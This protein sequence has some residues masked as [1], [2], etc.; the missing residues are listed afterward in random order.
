MANKRQRKKNGKKLQRQFDELM[1][2]VENESFFFDAADEEADDDTPFTN[3]F[4]R[5]HE[6]PVSSDLKREEDEKKKSTT[7]SYE[8]SYDYK[9]PLLEMT[10]KEENIT[11]RIS[12]LSRAQKK[13]AAIEQTIGKE[14]P[15]PSNEN[16][17]NP[18]GFDLGDI[19]IRPD[20][21]TGPIPAINTQRPQSGVFKK[22][23]GRIA[24]VA[25]SAATGIGIRLAFG[26]AAASLTTPL[27][28]AI[29]LGAAAGAASRVIV[30]SFDKEKRQQ[31][32]WWATEIIKGITIGSLTGG[33]SFG[34]TDVVMSSGLGH[35]LV[36]NVKD[37]MQGDS[38]LP[39]AEKPTVATIVTEAQAADAPITE[40]PSAT[41]PQ[42][43]TAEP[44]PAAPQLAAF[45]AKNFM[46]EEQFKGLPKHVQK[47]ATS[48]NP[49]KFLSFC[50]QAAHHLYNNAPNSEAAQK[51]SAGLLDYAT[52]FAEAHHITGTPVLERINANLAFLEA[53]YLKDIKS[54]VKH[55][56]RSGDAVNNY[57]SRLLKM[58]S[59][60]KIG[61]K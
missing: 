53:H 4:F 42:A 30:A 52:K 56:I 58:V 15:S 33:I 39:S 55:A 31:R 49:D 21:R 57:G 13:P 1:S 24:P 6:D 12:V 43:P 54:A 22:W 50:D 59:S 38:P 61:P 16:S 3:P 60:M 47:W 8:W 29:V 36:Q 19:P 34:I 41:E 11:S 37:F 10:Y 35:E 26:A 28:A 48:T 32:F 25:L 5:P 44:T 20:D 9:S 45:E 51:A 17:N 2:G 46:S 40:T 7:V 27:G 23:A 14:E 18:K